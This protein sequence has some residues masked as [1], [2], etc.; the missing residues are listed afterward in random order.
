MGIYLDNSATSFPKPDCVY[1]AI[2]DFMRNN[3][4][5]PGRG[6]YQSAMQSDQLVYE[7]RKSLTKLFNINRPGEIVFTANATESINIILKG[8]LQQGD[9][10]LTSNMEHNALWRPLKAL[11]RDRGIK[12]LQFHCDTTGAVDLQEVASLLSKKPKLLA[13]LH[14][15][16]VLGSVMPIKE[17]AALAH[18][19]GALVLVDA[20]Q[21]A[22]V[23][24][25]DVKAMGIDL[26]A[27]TGHKGLLG[28][29]GT[30]GFYVRE[31][32][33]LNTLKEGGTGSMAKSPYQP[34]KPPDR[35]EAGTMNI[36][37]IAGLHAAIPFLLDI[38][39]DTIRQHE[40][41]L[42]SILLDGVTSIPAVTLYGTDVPEQR[43]GLFSFN[44]DNMSAY[45][46]ANKLDKKYG[47]IVRAGLHCTPQAHELLG[48]QD[49]GTVRIST[50]WF[51][52]AEEMKAVNTAIKDIIAKG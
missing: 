11:E 17:M 31:G 33:A 10:V 20:A 47:I 3:G 28:P 40:T 49:V 23:Y 32:I 22:G 2:N 37:G 25:I 45:D 43:L 26:L 51:N 29:T 5:S 13:T 9:T 46:V 30:G 7:T 19:N 24:P 12:I 36:F 15:S 18:E 42:M 35:F 34:T 14:G 52:T 16:N 41:E 39:I 50:G 27:F 1:S 21:T 48:T 6:T 44:V 8:Y 38:G 4:A